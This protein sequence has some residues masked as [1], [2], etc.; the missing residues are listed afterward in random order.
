MW[1]NMVN[2][3]IFVQLKFAS[4]TLDTLI[5]FINIRIHLKTYFKIWLYVIYVLILNY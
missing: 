1:S 4:H 5:K 2:I 3:Y